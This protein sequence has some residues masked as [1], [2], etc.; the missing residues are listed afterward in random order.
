M[1]D[2]EKVTKGAK[3]AAK[4][5]TNGDGP[6]SKPAG[7]AVAGAALAA[8]PFAAEKLTGA[9]SKLADKAGDLTDDAKEKVK[10]ELKDT[11]KDA[12]PDSPAEMLGGGPLKKLFGG[13]GTTTTATT[14]TRAARRPRATGAAGG[15]RSSSRS[16]SR[17]PV[18]EV[19]NHWT[20]YE[21]W[22]EFMHR[23]ESA[24][25]VDETTVSFQAKIWG[26]SKR[27][28]AEIVEQR[29]DERIEWNVTEGY[30]HTGVVTFH[31]LSENL[32]RIDLSLDIQPANIID[33]AS[34]G[35]RFAKRAVRGDLHRF[36]AYAELDKE[37]KKGS[38]RTIEEGKV[39]RARRSGSAGIVD[40][41]AVSQSNGSDPKRG[42]KSKTSKGGP[43]AQS[44]RSKS[45]GGRS[46]SQ[47]KASAA[48]TTRSPPSKQSP[49]GGD[50]DEA[51]EENDGMSKAEE[52]E[53]GGK[54]M[55]R[56]PADEPD[57]Y[58]F[59]PE[60][61]VGKLEIDV[62]RLD[63]HLALQADVANLV[64]LVTGVHVGV[65]KVKI[66]L[67]DVTAEC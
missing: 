39:K 14:T 55:G 3:Q 8:I 2:I 22:P 32:T 61:H 62:E 10:S 64:K 35:M 45:G 41:A 58:V 66:D 19:F 67:E 25:Q 20:E 53:T 4:R 65:D 31:P 26:I 17:V 24:E 43:M 18:T 38:R 59:V 50:Q 11:A 54:A 37:R 7:L 40:R 42:S 48:R 49:T 46:G 16:T 52:S 63:A 47:R 30:A 27:F 60:V 29:P 56:P 15:C 34:R 9:G 36:K 57:V 6:L 13:G 23:I 51:E 44:K 28:E 33:K 21:D 12:L 1:A 5:V